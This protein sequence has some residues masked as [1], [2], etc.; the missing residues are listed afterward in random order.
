MCMQDIGLLAPSSPSWNQAYD[1]RR[2]AASMEPLQGGTECLF[3]SSYFSFNISE[4][5]SSYQRQAVFRPPFKICFSSTSQSLSPC[6]RVLAEAAIDQIAGRPGPP[7]S[8]Q[9]SKLTRWRAADREMG[10]TGKKFLSLQSAKTGQFLVPWSRLNSWKKKVAQM[11]RSKT[12]LTGRYPESLP[13]LYHIPSSATS[14][15]ASVALKLG[16]QQS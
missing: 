13:F 1:K 12:P 3:P 14:L 11:S 16:L 8:L 4:L 7:V 6:I 5:R 9:R 15:N 2:I 10:K